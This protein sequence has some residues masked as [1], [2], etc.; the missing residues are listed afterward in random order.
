[1]VN[2]NTYFSNELGN[3]KRK[4]DKFGKLKFIHI[5]TFCTKKIG[6]IWCL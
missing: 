4:K 2:E 3:H 5:L 1:M 6:W